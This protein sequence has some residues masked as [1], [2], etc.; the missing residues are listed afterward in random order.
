MSTA[1]P[2]IER[3]AETTLLKRA[4]DEAHKAA[5]DARRCAE[6]LDE[7]GNC[8]SNPA[9]MDRAFELRKLLHDKLADIAG[10]VHASDEW[11]LRR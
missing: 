3:Q 9:L 10:A 6:I 2:K 5:A 4:A 11:R 8:L 7:Y 1:K